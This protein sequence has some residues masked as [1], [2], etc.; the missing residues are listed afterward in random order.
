VGG[1]KRSWEDY[2]TRGNERGGNFPR[3]FLLKNGGI[4]GG[5]T[6]EGGKKKNLFPLRESSLKKRRLW[7]RGP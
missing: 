3:F 4:G 6:V 2:P 1:R 7:K 5:E